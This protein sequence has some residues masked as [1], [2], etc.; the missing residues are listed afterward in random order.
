MGS[1]GGGVQ[2]L[3]DTFDGAPGGGA[4]GFLCQ[5]QCVRGCLWGS[6]L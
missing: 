4:R 6:P 3:V 2:G 1:T 5:G